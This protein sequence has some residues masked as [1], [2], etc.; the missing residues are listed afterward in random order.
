M[1][2]AILASVLTQSKKVAEDKKKL[3]KLALK[4]SVKQ[5]DKTLKEVMQFSMLEEAKNKGKIDIKRI[6][7][8]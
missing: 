1:F 4:Q 8:N 2:E 7:H 5:D 6:K 3:D